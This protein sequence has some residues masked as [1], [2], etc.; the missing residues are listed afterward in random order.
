MAPR[1][2]ALVLG[3][4]V[5]ILVGIGVGRTSRARPVANEPGGRL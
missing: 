1:Q 5:V 2:L 4:V 3:G